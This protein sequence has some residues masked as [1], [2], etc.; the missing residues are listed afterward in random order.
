VADLYK[1]A[2]ELSGLELVLD[3]QRFEC[4]NS[5]EEQQLEG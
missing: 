2:C 3:G 5:W 1:Q 4:R